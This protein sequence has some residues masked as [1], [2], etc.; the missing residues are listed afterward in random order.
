LRN[1]V[2]DLLIMDRELPCGGAE[3]VLS[4][5]R[6]NPKLLPAQVLLTSESDSANDLHGLPNFALDQAMAKFIAVLGHELRGPLGA[7]RC[8]V[9]L[10]GHQ[11]DDPSTRE[12]LLAIVSR[13]TQRTSNVIEDM[14]DLARTGLNKLHLQKQPVNMA[15]LI[16]TAKETVLYH[17]KERQLH[18]TVSLPQE[19]VVL[20]AD[21]SRLQ[22]VLTNLLMNAIKY[23]N[24]DGCI[25]LT[26]KKK[27]DHVVLIVRDNGI[28]IAADMLPHIF[29]PF[30]QPRCTAGAQGGLGIGLALVRRFVEIHG[31][32]V[33]AFS[34]G[35]GQG[36]EFIVRLPCGEVKSM[37]SSSL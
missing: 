26:V 18:L 23:T 22:Q 24:A 5:L 10:L 1:A 2:P 27:T 29:Q 33:S 21:A 20:E 34:A 16:E 4:V 32:S 12:R 37:V 15:E 25:W 13:Q 35:P 6:E 9:E 7:I 36:A 28:G 11:G 19:P 8:A 14:L 17:L 31:G 30:W 3:G